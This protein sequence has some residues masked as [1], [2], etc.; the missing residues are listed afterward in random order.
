M[1]IEEAY[2]FCNALKSRLNP[3]DILLIG[4]DLKKN[5]HTIL[6]AYNDKAGITASFNLNLL[7][8]INEELDADFKTISSNITKPTIRFPEPAEVT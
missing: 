7:D 1:E 6:A 2:Q 3:D 4:F 8:R 5:P